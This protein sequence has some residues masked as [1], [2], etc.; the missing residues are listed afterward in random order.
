[1]D[2]KSTGVISYITIIGWILAFL[3][4]DREGAKFHLNQSLVLNLAN[5]FL[6]IVAKLLGKLPFVPFIVWVLDIVVF[7]FWIIGFVAA[8]KDEE[9]EVPVLG[10]IK[11]LQ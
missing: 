9:K 7:I 10:G 5:L 11:I 4:G 6:T 8:I 1:M 3:V 2:K